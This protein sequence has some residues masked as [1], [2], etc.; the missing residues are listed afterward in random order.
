[1]SPL[2]I[3]SAHL[4][5]AVEVNQPMVLLLALETLRTQ[6]LCSHFSFSFRLGHVGP[7]MDHGNTL[8]PIFGIPLVQLTL[9]PLKKRE[10]M[11]LAFVFCA[12][13][14]TPPRFLVNALKELC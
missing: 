7:F 9:L 1:M 5:G 13:R 6:G 3:A 8:P 12:P 11:R 14:R 2:L 4:C 10:W